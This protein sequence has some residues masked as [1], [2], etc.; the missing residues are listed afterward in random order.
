MK[1]KEHQELFEA[2]KRIAP[3]DRLLL[4]VY[5]NR[6]IGGT[7]FTEP[8]DLVHEAI[9]KIAEGRRKWPPGTDLAIYIAGTIRSIASNTRKRSEWSNISLDDLGEEDC[10]GARVPYEPT[11]STEDVALLNER[12]AV[13]IKAV[14]FAK[15]TLGKD[16]E[17][18]KVL[19]GMAAGLDP[20]DM[21]EAFDMVPAAVKA[22][23][24]RVIK[25]LRLYGKRNPL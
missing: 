1:D 3:H 21:C 7:H 20:K 4:E 15:D 22:A 2:Y 13:S 8:M 19:E 12:N 18:R 16:E 14:N 5:A 9:F 11:M 6:W 17:G 24:Q 25:R 23:R 10:S